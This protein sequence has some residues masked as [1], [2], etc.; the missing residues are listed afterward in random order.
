MPSATPSADHEHHGCASRV[1]AA[2]RQLFERLTQQEKAV[3][4]IRNIRVAKPSGKA[5]ARPVAIEPGTFPDK[6]ARGDGPPGTIANVRHMLDA[7]GVGVRYNIVKRRTEIVVPWLIGTAENV[8]SVAMTHVLSL[9]LLY[10]VPTGHVPAMVEALGDENAY[11]P[12][13]DWINGKAWDG[14]DRLD[15]M[16]ATIVARDGY[17]EELKRTLMHRWLLSGA[18]AAL[19]P[20]GFHS[21][22]VLTLQG[23][24]GIGKTSWGLA[25]VDDPALRDAVIRV[26]HHLD[27]GD[28]DSLLGAVE[29]WIVEI[30]ELDSSLRRD[31]ARLKGF[32]TSGADKIRRPYARVTV[33]YPRRTCFYATVNASDFLVDST[34]NSRFWT[35]AVERIDHAHGID[36]QQLWAQMA[37]ELKGGAQWWLTA[38]EERALEV[39][40]AQHRSFSLV[41]D[42]IAEVVDI[43][44]TNTSACAAM[45]AS[46][47]LVEAGF[48]NPT[49]T[50]AKECAGHLREW[51]GDSKRINGRDRWR[52]PLL[53]GEGDHR[54]KASDKPP[55]SKFD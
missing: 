41:R 28:K 17:P 11:N 44:A 5:A 40:N 6:P 49:N 7:N 3:N 4:Q 9:A 25:L 55:K 36:V 22:G 18:A 31:V 47:V 12:V 16:Y 32:I 2:S 35:I 34:G 46:E 48:T 14:V 42:R 20:V 43:E 37:V 30:G 15:A 21:R 33:S 38:D 10:R 13:A 27:A 45:T 39:Q 52:V 54:V 19:T 23:P 1:W 50:Q 24:Q 26:D 8:D 53:P 29:H 51:F